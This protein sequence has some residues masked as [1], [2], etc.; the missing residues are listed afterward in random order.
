MYKPE[1]ITLKN[2]KKGMV[3]QSYHVSGKHEICNGSI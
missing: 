2:L 1:N 3:G